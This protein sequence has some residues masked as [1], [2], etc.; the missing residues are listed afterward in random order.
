[1]C[2]NISQVIK[3]AHLRAIQGF[4]DELKSLSQKTGL[5]KSTILQEGFQLMKKRRGAIEA[6]AKQEGME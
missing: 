6:T 2:N 4:W 5:G 1:M 3:G